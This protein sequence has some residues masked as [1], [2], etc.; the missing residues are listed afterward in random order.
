MRSVVLALLVLNTGCGSSL[1]IGATRSTDAV[2][3]YANT[4]PTTRGADPGQWAR[5]PVDA[6]PRPIVLTEAQV[7]DP[8]TG[9]LTDFAKRVVPLGS[10][11]GPTVWP[12][13]PGAVDG[14]PIVDARV[15]FARLT[16]NVVLDPSEP[17]IVVTAVA[18]ASASFMTDRGERQLPA[19]LFSLDR[20]D[21]QVAVVAVAE[22]ALFDWVGAA[23]FGR[24][25][26]ISLDDRE[27]SLTF[28]G[29][30]AG[31]GPCTA[32]YELDVVESPTSVA[33]S[34]ETTRSGGGECNSGGHPRAASVT[35]AAPLGNRVV[36]IGGNP[37]DAA[38][39]GAPI[40]VIAS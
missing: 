5:F 22:P 28:V 8:T 20:D 24:T 23:Q 39:R 25:A 4:S 32:D 10:I 7:V 37:T 33:V 36:V 3:P 27:L 31:T 17:H 12:Q 19:W 21:S 35:L 40:A 2:A 18:L 1:P 34:V 13:P 16:A 29:A 11:D 6:E 15:A 26:S 30:Q 9:F 38:T 14:Q